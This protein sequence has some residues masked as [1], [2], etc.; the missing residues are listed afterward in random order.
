MN[1]RLYPSASYHTYHLHT[2]SINR[3]ILEIRA[4]TSRSPLNNS[5]V[6]SFHNHRL[7]RHTWLPIGAAA[8]GIPRILSLANLSMQVASVDE[9]KHRR[10]QGK[11]ENI[12][13]GLG[14]LPHVGDVGSPA[15]VVQINVTILVITVCDQVVDEGADFV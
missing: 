13:L 11:G 14:H 3:S 15:V 7:S 5:R 2:L 8:L 9:E 6:H 12:L 1:E 4:T 10:Q